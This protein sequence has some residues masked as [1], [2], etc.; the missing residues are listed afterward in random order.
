VSLI[1]ANLSCSSLKWGADVPQPRLNEA[2]LRRTLSVP[3]ANDI[4][5]LRL[6]VLQNGLSR[7]PIRRP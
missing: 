7:V 1:S 2:A 6:G 4:G 3:R 5:D